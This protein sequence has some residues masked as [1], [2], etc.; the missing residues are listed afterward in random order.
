M[1]RRALEVGA[2]DESRRHL[3]CLCLLQTGAAALR[4]RLSGWQSARRPHWRSQAL[5]ARGLRRRRARCKQ[6][7]QILNT[8]CALCVCTDVANKSYGAHAAT[9]SI[10]KCSLTAPMQ[11]SAV[12]VGDRQLGI[13]CGPASSARHQSQAGRRHVAA[14]GAHVGSHTNTGVSCVRE[15]TRNCIA[16]SSQL[17]RR[18]TIAHTPAGMSSEYACTSGA[19]WSRLGVAAQ[20]ASAANVRCT[21]PDSSVQMQCRWVHKSK[22]KGTHL[23]L[24][25]AFHVA[26]IGR[27][28]RTYLSTC[29]HAAVA[30]FHS[31][32]VHN[33][34]FSECNVA[35]AHALVCRRA[36]MQSVAC[37]A[38]P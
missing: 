8:Q 35:A 2:Q 15:L 29:E 18:A 6:R 14:G 7:S 5:A 22:T 38:R 24:P 11:S 31:S 21:L 36:V 25:R 3:V 23:A 13:A 12:C 19:L 32:T 33:G 17:R 20:A 34:A 4:D 10:L 9:R 30:R 27:M 26:L 28:Q 1:R 37:A 16:R